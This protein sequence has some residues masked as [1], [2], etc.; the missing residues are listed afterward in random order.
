MGRALKY[1]FRIAVLG[2]L[3][4]AAYAMLADLPPPTRDVVVDLPAPGASN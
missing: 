3:A 1:L 4:L 2:T